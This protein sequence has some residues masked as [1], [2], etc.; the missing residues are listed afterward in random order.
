[1]PVQT[2]LYSFLAHVEVMKAV[3]ATITDASLVDKKAQRKQSTRGVYQK[4]SRHSRQASP[5]NTIHL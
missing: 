2:Y 5:S 3:D 1:M 4:Q